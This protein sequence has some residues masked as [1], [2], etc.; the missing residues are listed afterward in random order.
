MS[1]SDN[2]SVQEILWNFSCVK[3]K[4]RRLTLRENP[5]FYEILPRSPEGYGDKLKIDPIE[6]FRHAT[7]FYV[8]TDKLEMVHIMTDQI[9]RS[10]VNFWCPSTSII[11]K[12]LCVSVCFLPFDSDVFL[13]LRGT[14][15]AEGIVMASLNG[16]HC[17]FCERLPVSAVPGTSTNSRGLPPIITD[18]CS[19][20]G[21]KC[22]IGSLPM[23]S[24]DDIGLR[25]CTGRAALDI[26]VRCE[27]LTYCLTTSANIE[28]APGPLTA[29]V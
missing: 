8:L 20:M 4:T 3:D 10:F 21:W 23:H 24:S 1:L 7:F 22:S 6:D 18:V 13:D 16:T 5:H 2:P 11:F 26:P 9:S 29:N 25:I 28:V 12:G 14:L 17:G 15:T 27:I 19:L